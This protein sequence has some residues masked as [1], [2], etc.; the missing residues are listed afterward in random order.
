[1]VVV[2]NYVWVNCFFMIF[3]ICQVF[4]K[5]FNIIFD[6]LDLYVI[7]DVFYNIVKVEQYVVDGKEWILLVYRKGFICVFFFYYF[8]IVVDY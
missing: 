4:V 7:Y 2:G 6:D 1:M 8:F 5:V 3:L